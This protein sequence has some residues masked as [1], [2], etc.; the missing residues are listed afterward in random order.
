MNKA[1]CGD[2]V[3]LSYDGFAF[4]LTTENGYSETNRIVLEPEVWDT[5]QSNVNILKE[6]QQLD[7]N[8]DDE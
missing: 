4:V 7:N 5:V 2:G 1:Y 3:Y 8:E 6:V